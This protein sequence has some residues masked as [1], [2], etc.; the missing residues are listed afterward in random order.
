MAKL[1]ANIS[2]V[3]IREFM[4]GLDVWKHAPGVLEL[5]YPQ[6]DNIIKLQKLTE[7]D[8][9]LAW[10]ESAP[11]VPH[12]LSP[13]QPVRKYEFPS[14]PLWKLQIDDINVSNNDS[15]YDTVTIPME[16]YMDLTE[17]ENDLAEFEKWLVDVKKVW[18]KLSGAM[19]DFGIGKDL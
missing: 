5:H 17:K 2:I 12:L 14:N 3:L 11:D 16:R 15:E 8:S 9:V 18:G 13:S 1:G 7:Q 10:Y 19:K 4:D 6:G